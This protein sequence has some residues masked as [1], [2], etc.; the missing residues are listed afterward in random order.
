[1]P[2][3]VVRAW[4][5]RCATHSHT[6]QQ[7]WQ[8]YSSETEL[9]LPMACRGADR[10]WARTLTFIPRRGGTQPSQLAFAQTAAVLC[11]L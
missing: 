2:K 3:P 7:H 10:S 5:D 9:A 11:T 4:T 1:M 8:R 6:P